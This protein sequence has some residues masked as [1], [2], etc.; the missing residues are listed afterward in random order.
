MVLRDGRIGF[1]DF[2]IVGRIPE[3]AWQAMSDFIS[4]IM[5]GNFEGMANAMLRIGITKNMWM[6]RISQTISKDFIRSW[7]LMLPNYENC[8]QTM[9]KRSTGV[10]GYC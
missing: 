9:R 7:I 3:G 1:I 5:T 6:N 4:S 2:G 8:L 10:D